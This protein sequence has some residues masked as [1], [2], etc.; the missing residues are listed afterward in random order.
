[1]MTGPARKSSKRRLEEEAAGDCPGGHAGLEAVDFEALQLPSSAWLEA[2]PRYTCPACKKSFKTNCYLCETVH[3][4]LASKPLPQIATE[5]LPANLHVIRHPMCKVAKSSIFSVKLLSPPD[6][7]YQVQRTKELTHNAASGGNERKPGGVPPAQPGS[8]ISVADFDERN[9]AACLP[10][11]LEDCVI[12]YPTDDAKAVREVDWVSK[13]KTAIIVDCTWFET[14]GILKHLEHLPKIKIS[15]KATKYWRHHGRRGVTV[16]NLTPEHLCTIEAGY[17]LEREIAEAVAA[18]KGAGAAD[19]SEVNKLLFFFKH[20]YDLIQ[21]IF[22]V[23]NRNFHHRPGYVKLDDRGSGA[24]VATDADET[25]D[26][27]R[28]EVVA[29]PAKQRKRSV[30]LGPGSETLS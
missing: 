29:A 11:N 18:S 13:R 12:L 30:D 16:R 6:L 23:E 24:Q 9:L 15:A 17:W 4:E 10:A 22:K 25:A 2:L 7:S 1:M 5:D 26:H 3:P 19:L 21:H 27:E 8:W 14:Y 20:N 28:T